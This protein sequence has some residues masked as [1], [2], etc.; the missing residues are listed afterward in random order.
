MPVYENIYEF[1]NTGL[2]GYMFKC[3]GCCFWGEIRRVGMVFCGCP[4]LGPA[5]FT[6]LREMLPTAGSYR[7]PLQTLPSAARSDLAEP[8]FLPG[9]RLHPMTGSYV[10]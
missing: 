2:E 9:D 1:Q 4:F 7:V 6:Q 8:K 10:V 5:H 3:H